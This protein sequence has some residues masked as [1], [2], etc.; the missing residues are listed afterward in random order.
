MG[1]RCADVYFQELNITGMW[2]ERKQTGGFHF[3]ADTADCKGH[4]TRMSFETLDLK[5]VHGCTLQDVHYINFYVQHLST[6]RMT[7]GGLLGEDD[8]AAETIPSPDCSHH[9]SFH[10]DLGAGSDVA[11]FAE[12]NM[13]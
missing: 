1:A 6:I 12:A 11:S 7:I 8:H 3:L 13:A 4:S 2:A 5:V 9:T 10:S